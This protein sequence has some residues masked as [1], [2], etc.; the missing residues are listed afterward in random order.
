[1]DG[2]FAGSW[3]AFQANVDA[4]SRDRGRRFTLIVDGRGA[5]E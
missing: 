2:R 4:V 5:R 1:V 3:T